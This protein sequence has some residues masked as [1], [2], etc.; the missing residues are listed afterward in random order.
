MTNI[1]NATKEWA[2]KI[3]ALDLEILLA[4]SLGKPREFILAHPEF[5]IDNNQQ[6]KINKLIK[7]RIKGEPIAYITGC[8]EFYG[9]D[10]L[11]N[12]HTLIP[13]PETE[14]I[15]DNVLQE[16]KNEKNELS[17]IDVGTGSGNI[18]ISIAK[19]IASKNNKSQSAKFY[20]TDISDKALTIAK[21]NAKIHD[22]DKQIKFLKGDLLS[23][24][25]PLIADNRSLI[26]VSN[27]P[28]LSKRLYESA[29]RDVKNYEPKSALY[30]RKHGLAHYEKLLKQI[31][32]MLVTCH[33]S[34][35]TCFMEISPEQKS[36]ISK[37]IKKNFPKA[38]ITFK[39]DLAN[40]HRLC[41]IKIL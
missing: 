6:S 9:L 28:Y 21:K 14:L 29:S 31:K 23:P 20:A 3:N 4:Y 19:K 30:S 34:N 13:R 39:R 33:L 26:I 22:V 17:I 15:V 40:K 36:L 25:L 1:G 16:S 11:V 8:K 10:F 2:D 35:V 5:L 18:A 24:T 37:T 38:K 41:R 12:K 7:R 32:K 27:L